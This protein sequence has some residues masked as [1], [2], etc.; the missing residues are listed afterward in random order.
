[1]TFETKDSGQRQEFD[2]GARRD[3]QDGKP[4]FDLIPVYVLFE[5]QR[6]FADN[7][8]GMPEIETEPPDMLD[9]PEQERRDDL[10]PEYA[11]HRLSALFKRGADKYGENNYQRGIPLSRI[12]ASAFRHLIYWYMGD[13]S[14]DHLAALAINAFFAIMMEKGVFDGVLPKSIGD[15]GWLK[16]FS[17]VK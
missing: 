17:D 9:I 11:L 2:T 5:L 1:M 6:L 15:A 10:L 8:V 3:T 12:Y 7:N 4:R 16:E 13:T 14:E